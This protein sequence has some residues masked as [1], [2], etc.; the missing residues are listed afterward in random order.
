MVAFR[1]NTS[2]LLLTSAFVLLMGC[3]VAAGITF[4]VFAANDCGGADLDK[5]CDVSF[6]DFAILAQHWLESNC[7]SSNNCGGA[8][9]IHNNAV[10]IHCAGHLNFQLP[11]FFHHNKAFLSTT[12]FNQ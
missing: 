9:L 6:T 8:D 3:G 5:N 2:I 1:T 11:I 10:F 12:V 4:Y 7:Y